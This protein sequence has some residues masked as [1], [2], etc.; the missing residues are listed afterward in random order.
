[1]FPILMFYKRIQFCKAPQ[2]TRSEFSVHCWRWKDPHLYF[3]LNVT[4]A[5]ILNP[6]VFTWNLLWA[7]CEQVAAICFSQ[8]LSWI[9]R[10]EPGVHGA[11]GCP[12][13][14]AALSRITFH[15]RVPRPSSWEEA[16]SPSPCPSSQQLDTSLSSPC[17]PPDYPAQL[18]GPASPTLL[19]W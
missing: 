1:M 19:P 5:L 6:R 11:G 9:C 15:W 10:K 7:W 16:I 2:S 4:W 17:R 18:S 12:A 8:G 13:L 3:T 14:R